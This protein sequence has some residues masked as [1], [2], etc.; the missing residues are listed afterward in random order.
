MSPLKSE[1]IR[2]EYL[3]THQRMTPFFV[4]MVLYFALRGAKE[5]SYCLPRVV[6]SLLL[7]LSA[8]T[9][10]GPVL[11]AIT[12]LRMQENPSTSP[13]F[14]M[15]RAV[16]QLKSEIRCEKMIQKLANTFSIFIRNLYL[17]CSVAQSSLLLPLI[18]SMPRSFQRVTVQNPA[19]L[20]KYLTRQS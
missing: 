14:V 9:F 17:M 11:L 10:L 8:F 15:V 2:S 19:L 16:L 12:K 13:T 3:T 6:H 7:V 5:R 20:G 1:L 18:Y 4:G